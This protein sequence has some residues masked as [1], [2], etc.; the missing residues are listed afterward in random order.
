MNGRQPQS[1]HLGVEGIASIQVLGQGFGLGGVACH[2]KGQSGFGGRASALGRELQGSGGRLPGLLQGAIR[3]LLQR[4][5][6][7]IDCAILLVV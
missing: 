7:Q 2:G 6:G 1:L 4:R 5:I 3:R